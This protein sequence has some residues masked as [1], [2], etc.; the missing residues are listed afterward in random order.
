MKIGIITDSTCDLPLELLQQYSILS[1]P[2]H[3]VWGER[4]FRDWHDVKP[5]KLYQ[6][7]L[8]QDSA[9]ETATPSKQMFMQSYRQALEIYDVLFS[10]H[11]SSQISNVYHR[12]RGT[13]ERLHAEKRVIFIDS[14]AVNAS[15][16]SIVLNLAENIAR[17]I[18][19]TQHLLAEAL[20]V[21]DNMVALYAPYSYKWLVANGHF[22][23]AR[24][25][26][27]DMR[28]TRPLVSLENGAFAQ[29]GTVHRH[30]VIEAMVAR[31]ERAF[32]G[33]PVLVT[34]S[35]AGVMPLVQVEFQKQLEASNLQVAKARVQMIGTAIGTHLGPSTV[36]ITAFHYEQ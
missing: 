28:N 31:L 12:A 10:V 21:R 29:A 22:P 4:V 2:L 19:D 17:G 7:M 18:K 16:A 36:G 33:L 1:M 25:T 15:L 23:A 34:L 27:E 32:S 8:E 5:V 3:V 26:L 13:V 30:D 6:R 35:T 11:V 24:A 20:Y 9:P 14:F